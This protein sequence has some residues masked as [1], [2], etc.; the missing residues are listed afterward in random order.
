MNVVYLFPYQSIKKGSRVAIYGAGLVGQDYMRQIKETGY[1]NIAFVADANYANLIPER[2]FGFELAAPEIFQSRNDFEYIVLATV[3]KENQDG[4]IQVLENANI[5][6]EKMIFPQVV[7]RVRDITYS[8]HGE[9]RIIYE[10]FKHMGFFRDGNLPTYIDVGAH[11]PY[12]ISNT[13][14]F[15]QMGCHGINIEANPELIEAFK[16]ERPD[17]INLCFGIGAEEGTLPF[18]ITA[19]S[20]LNT[21]KRENLEYNEF[22]TE[23]N[24]GQRECFDIK[25][26]IDIPIKKL[27]DVINE[28]NDGKWP[29][30]M[31]M[32]I[33]GMEYESL[34]DIDF[35]NGPLMIAVEVNYNGDLFIEMMRDKNY[36]PYLWYRENILFV[37]NDMEKL[38]HNHMKK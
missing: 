31:S 6:K 34:R 13:A 15:Y 8:Q 30:F 33:E 19:H 25:K 28:Y 1:C 14:L 3:N 12:E 2:C 36:F 38:V 27:V 24:T 23:Q 20:G 10:A 32:D 29:E 17:D 35:S 21:F 11:H 22:L 7:Y 9:D 26:V 18:Y 5:S 16:I 37:R 4:M